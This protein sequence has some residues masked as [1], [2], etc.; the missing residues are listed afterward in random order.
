MSDTFC[1][2]QLEAGSERGRGCVRVT[3]DGREYVYQIAKTERAAF[4]QWAVSV[5][6]GGMN[7]K[8]LVGRWPEYEVRQPS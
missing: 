4:K 7:A 3:D 6:A 5:F 2:R 8:R 1:H